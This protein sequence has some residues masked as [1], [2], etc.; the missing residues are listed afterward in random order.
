M[1]KD[2]ARLPK[3]LFLAVPQDR[4]PLQPTQM[5]GELK[6][7]RASP[8]SV[9]CLLVGKSIV[10]PPQNACKTTQSRQEEHQTLVRRETA[11][12]TTD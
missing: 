6:V 1:T 9:M 12:V 10:S 8:L 5:K 4:I 3:C 2:N 7:T 11:A